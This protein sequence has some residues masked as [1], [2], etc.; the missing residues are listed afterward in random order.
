MKSIFAAGAAMFTL[1][2]CTQEVQTEVQQPYT[3]V[4]TL[5]SVPPDI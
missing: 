1:T 2:A 5:A 3:I 4:T